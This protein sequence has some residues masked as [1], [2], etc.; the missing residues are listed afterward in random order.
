MYLDKEIYTAFENIVGPENICGDPA[1]MASY[2][3]SEIG[4]VVLPKDSEEVQAVVRLCNK[5]KIQFTAMSTAFIRAIMPRG[6]IYLDLRRMNHIIEIN[7]ENMYA[8][9]E[10]YVTSAELQ[11]ELL[12]RGLNCSI[13]GSGAQCT[14]I[15]RGHGHMD[16][17]TG[18]DDRNQLGME[19][20]TPAGDLIRLGSTG[21]VN[22]WFCGD[23]PGPSLRGVISGR[24][25]GDALAEGGVITK[26]AMKLYHW[27]G[28]AEFALEG[29]SPNY[30]LGEKLPPNF[31]VRYYSFPSY[32][33]MYEAELK[34]GESEIMFELMGFNV[35]MLSANVSSTLEKELQFLEQAKKQVQGPGFYI[36]IAANSPEEFEYD[37]KVLQQIIS[38]TN[39]KSLELI[40]DPKAA[41]LILIHGVRISASIRETFRSRAP[42]GKAYGF[43]IM[44]QRDVCMKWIGEAAARKKNLIEQGLGA[45]DGGV[46]FGWGVEN[47]HLGKTEIFFDPSTDPKSPEA[48]MAWQQETAWKALNDHLAVPTHLP[49]TTVGPRVSNYHLWSKKMDEA[50]NPNCVTVVLPSLMG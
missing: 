28:P 45:D 29:Q 12:K 21:S 17:S 2:H 5:L 37:Q 6:S 43:Q 30:G 31:M 48:I 49:L 3:D 38:E 13:K 33:K 19:W 15:I 25:S 22:E 9:V 46:F 8:V 24:G 47:S 26:A 18:G 34:I 39:G 27:P 41:E 35:A 14:A 42:G 44:G 32:D 20:V 11:A 7:E 40:E 10:P 16:M 1:I 36:I 23:G 50:F 4:A